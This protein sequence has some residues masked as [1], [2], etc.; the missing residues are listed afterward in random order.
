MID[1]KKKTILFVT[2]YKLKEIKKLLP[3]KKNFVLQYFNCNNP[4][5][6]N[7]LNKYLNK[8]ISK[9]H[10]LLSFSNNYIF[11]Q[12]QLRSFK[13]IHKI[14]FHPGL[15]N[16]PGRDVSHF[17][18]YNKEKVFGGTMHSISNKIDNGDIID[19][20]AIKINR[21]KPDHYYFSFI[22]HRAIRNL[23]QKNFSKILNSKIFFKR[24]NW[25]KKLYTRKKFLKMQYVKKDISKEKLDH[26]KRSFYTPNYKSLYQINNNKKV[27]LKFN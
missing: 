1:L 14:N 5:H 12:K 19:T 10:I 27:F 25:S 2:N 23:L 24:K 21:D 8:D 11:K 17:A 16:Y 22:G 7:K 20:K 26:L 6:L 4:L 3:K 13:K 18:C 15:P 9:N